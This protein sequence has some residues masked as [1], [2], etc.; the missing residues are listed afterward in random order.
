MDTLTTIVKRYYD[1][2]TW[3]D[4]TVLDEDSFNLLQDILE[5]G[6]VITTRAPYDKLVT[7]TYAEKAK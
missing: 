4:N 6:G 7:T 2:Q 5:D 1:Q 3:K